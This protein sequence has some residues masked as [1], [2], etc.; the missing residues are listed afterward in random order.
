MN[1]WDG[2]CRHLFTLDFL[3]S[4]RNQ[5]SMLRY[6]VIISDHTA[7]APTIAILGKSVWIT[8]VLG[9]SE[10]PSARR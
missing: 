6:I 2:L 7:N 5:S 8:D 10:E 3:I 4:D 9:K 1:T